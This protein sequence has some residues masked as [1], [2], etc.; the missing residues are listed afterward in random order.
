MVLDRADVRLYGNFP[1]EL[2]M[3]YAVRTVTWT[4]SKVIRLGACVS[5]W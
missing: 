3:A 1:V 5:K 2:C 4:I